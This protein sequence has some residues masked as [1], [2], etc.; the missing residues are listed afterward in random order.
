M[1][2]IKVSKNQITIT[3]HADSHLCGCVSVLIQYI[4]SCLDVVD[5]KSGYGHV[6][7]NFND[8]KTSEML[9]GKFVEFIKNMRTPEIHIEINTRGGLF[10]ACNRCNGVS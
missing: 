1:I 7:V 9:I 4:A 8:N 6:M 10:E 2:H 3:G 5:Y